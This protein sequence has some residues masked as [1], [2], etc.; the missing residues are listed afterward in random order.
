RGRHGEPAAAH[1]TAPDRVARA[2]R[3]TARRAHRLRLGSDRRDL[4]TC[5]GCRPSGHGVGEGGI[6]SEM[7]LSLLLDMATDVSPDRVAI[8]HPDG[9]GLPAT[10]LRDRA[11]RAAGRFAD[12]SIT[13]VGF[14]ATNGIA[15]PIS[16]FGAAIAGK[17]FVP[18]NYRLSEEQLSDLLTRT[19]G[20]TVV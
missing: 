5:G 9:T 3:R 4:L 17:P 16:L 14:L 7:E 11:R 10:E 12:P 6:G 8:T 2:H 13:Q 20:M 19:E 18:L 1:G 15:L